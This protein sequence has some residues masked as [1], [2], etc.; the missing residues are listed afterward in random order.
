MV[1]MQREIALLQAEPCEL[2]MFAEVD[3]HRQSNTE[4]HAKA[5]TSNNLTF[6]RP[7]NDR[8]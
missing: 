4:S 3:T 6:E 1:A 8:A 2:H 7:S 5:D